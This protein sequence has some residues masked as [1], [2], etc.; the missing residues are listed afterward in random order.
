MGR[1]SPRGRR[2]RRRVLW[3]ALHDPHGTR[4]PSSGGEQVDLATTADAEKVLLALGPWFESADALVPEVRHRLAQRRARADLLKHEEDA[5]NSALEY[6][7]IPH[8]FLKGSALE[9]LDP[10]HQRQMSDLDLMLPDEQSAWL[11]VDLLQRLEY[12]LA[13]MSVSIGGKQ[14]A[15]WSGTIILENREGSL[16]EVNFGD[17]HPHWSTQLNLPPNFFRS[18]SDASGPY[19]SLRWTAAIFVAELVDRR[20][21]ALRDR[22]DA[23]NIFGSLTYADVAWLMA[24][25]RE[26]G[27]MGEMALLAQDL[28]W[29]RSPRLGSVQVLLRR[30]WPRL[31]RALWHELAASRTQHGLRIAVRTAVAGGLRDVLCDLLQSG[32]VRA[33]ARHVALVAGRR[34]L[35][36][37]STLPTLAM[38]VPLAPEPSTGYDAANV[39]GLRLS[40]VGGRRVVESPVGTFLAMS[41]PVISEAER[42]RLGNTMRAAASC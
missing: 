16:V 13:A 35:G 42:V 8:S 38:L 20:Y 14:D 25:A 33:F 27:L 6:A 39:P 12:N 7:G 1:Q 41:V 22:L 21:L 4:P 5:I 2:S 17:L 19:P 15:P 37:D 10:H 34:G 31:T 23:R 28:T 18:G 32:R 11:A 24:F 26:N 3:D 9:R 30:Y 29:L 40:H 36:I